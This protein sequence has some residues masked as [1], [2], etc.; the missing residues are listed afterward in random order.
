MLLSA[1]AIQVHS[2]WMKLLTAICAGV[3]RFVFC[4]PLS[5]FLTIP[6]AISIGLLAIFPFV[7]LIVLARDGIVAW[8]TPRMSASIPC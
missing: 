4:N 2:V 1:H 5:A 8:L 7:L 3:C 6:I